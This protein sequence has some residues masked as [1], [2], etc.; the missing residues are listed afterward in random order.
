MRKSPGPSCF[1]FQ[2]LM[3]CESR[4]GNPKPQARTWCLPC[5]TARRSRAEAAESNSEVHISR[6]LKFT[7]R[8]RSPKNGRRVRSCLHARKTEHSTPKQGRGAFSGRRVTVMIKS[9]ELSQSTN[10]KAT[11]D[12]RPFVHSTRGE[13]GAGPANAHHRLSLN[14][15]VVGAQFM[16][17]SGGQFHGD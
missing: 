8:K 9:K 4:S 7:W 15:A 10:A 14:A 5:L 17:L 3:R 11:L 6:S 16:V 12:R 13:R 1:C 2:A